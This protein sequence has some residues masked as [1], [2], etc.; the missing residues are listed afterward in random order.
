MSHPLFP[1]PFYSVERRDRQSGGETVDNNCFLGSSIDLCV[2][3]MRRNIDYDPNRENLWY[4]AVVTMFVDSD[5]FDA[6][7]P[8]FNEHGCIHSYYDWDGNFLQEQP[9]C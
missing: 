5:M 1:N 9:Y 4:W 8:H 7:D 6:T 3:W 2:A